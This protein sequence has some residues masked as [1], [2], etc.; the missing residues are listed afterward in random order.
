LKKEL[1]LNNDKIINPKTL[2]LLKRDGRTVKEILEGCQSIPKQNI[3]KFLQK[4]EKLLT[5]S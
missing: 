5:M 1:A 4:Q 2:R 3:Q